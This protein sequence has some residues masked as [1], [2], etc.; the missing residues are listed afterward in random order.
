MQ[1]CTEIVPGE[2][3]PLRRGLNP[4]TVMLDIHRVRKNGKL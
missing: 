3:Q 2:P 4:N 1:N